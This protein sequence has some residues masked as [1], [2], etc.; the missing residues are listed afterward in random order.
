MFMFNG[1][2][3]IVLYVKDFVILLVMEIVKFY[4]CKWEKSC[5]DM[6]YEVM[7]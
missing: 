3:F 7:F 1:N 5:M 4:I 2:K 6:V